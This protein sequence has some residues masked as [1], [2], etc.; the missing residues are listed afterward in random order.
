MLRRVLPFLALSIGLTLTAWFVSAATL[1][2]VFQNFGAIGWG[3]LAVVLVRATVIATNGLAWATLLAKL[4]KVPTDVFALLRW[5]R[6]AIDV[7]LPVASVGGGLVSARMLTFWG[8]SGAMAT[9]GLVAD[10]FLQT[11]AQV[12]F[13]L[14]GT[15][16]LVKVVGPDTVLPP[17]LLAMAAALLVL[18][19]F[20]LVQRQKGA[21]AIELALAAL[22]ARL[23]PR[24]QK[25]VA[26]FHRA[27]DV[28]WRRP[29]CVLMA[30]V[31]HVLAWT[32]GTLEVLLTFYF[33]GRPVPLEHAV[34]LESLGTT[35]SIAAFFVPGSWG[36]QEGGYIL[37]G[38]ML[39]LPPYLSL[40]LSFVKRVPDFLLGLS[41]LAVWQG[42][43]A[44][45]AATPGVKA[46][47]N[48]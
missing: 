15:M 27:T 3:I 20:Y 5:I 26:E 25:G 23:V 48:K 10:V 42:I 14:F 45:H 41:G 22:F 18:G 46:K 2:A 11:S 28:I 8:V 4:C 19:A 43:E 38:E 36:V 6:E 47:K 24:A 31:V 40:S 13:A 29:G 17:L 1:T 7:T 21:R 9:A 39:G 12:M 33:L 34:I 16:L 32:F 44:R 37:I 30:L 35:I